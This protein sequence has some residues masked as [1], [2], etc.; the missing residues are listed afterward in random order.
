MRLV[1]ETTHESIQEDINKLA[2]WSDTMLMKFNLDKCHVM[3][4][5]ANN[6]H[7]TYTIPSTIF[8]EEKA[9]SESYYYLFP[10]IDLV[11]T[12]KDLGVTVDS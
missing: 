10:A 7:H 5:G 4:L 9:N 12:K 11:E 2:A 6:P 8:H 3:H 1:N